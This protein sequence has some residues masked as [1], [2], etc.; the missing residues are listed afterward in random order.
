MASYAEPRLKSYLADADLS[1]LQYTFVKLGTDEKHV[2]AQ[3]TKGGKNL[4]IL[5]NKPTSG[6]EAVVALPGGGAKL[7]VSETVAQLDYLISGTA[8]K[9]EQADAAGQHVGAMAHDAGVTNDIVAVD[10]VAFESFDAN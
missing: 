9:G 5:M 1:A 10:V 8:G 6:Q 2:A 7:K 4:G 3:T